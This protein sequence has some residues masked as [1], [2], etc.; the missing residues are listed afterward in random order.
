MNESVP[1]LAWFLICP[2]ELITRYLLHEPS[3]G[4]L[5]LNFRNHLKKT[6]KGWQLSRNK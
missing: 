6:L 1:V 4:D 2:K 3:P 5:C